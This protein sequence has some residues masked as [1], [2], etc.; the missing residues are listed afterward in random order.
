M[1]NL[2]SEYVRSLVA[3]AQK[4]FNDMQKTRGVYKKIK[5]EYSNLRNFHE[6]GYRKLKFIDNDEMFMNYAQLLLE[7]KK[8]LPTLENSV[9]IAQQNYHRAKEKQ[10]MVQ[11]EKKYAQIYYPWLEKTCVYQLILDQAG[12]WKTGRLVC[13][14]WNNY[15]ISKPRPYIRF[16]KKLSETHLSGY[17]RSNFFEP[18]VYHD[19]PDFKLG[20]NSQAFYDFVVANILADHDCKLDIF[21]LF[22]NA[23]K[24]FTKPLGRKWH[25]VKYILPKIKDTESNRKKIS[26]Y[27]PLTELML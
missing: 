21:T 5:K 4:L 22:V 8:K 19:I 15:L 16:N 26:Y 17:S 6:D 24:F 7:A 23:K 20:P 13:K 3:E 9:L 14:K 2:N 18:P 1:I 27:L 25:V 10:L 11:E 12:M